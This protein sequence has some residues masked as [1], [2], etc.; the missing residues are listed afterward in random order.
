MNM[1]ILTIL[2]VDDEANMRRIMEATLKREGYTTITAANGK[3]ALDYLDKKPIHI[4]LTDLRMPVIDGM[5]L[6][7]ECNSRYPDIP[8]I[9]LT[10]HGTVETAVEAMKIGAFDYI[11]KPFDIIEMRHALTKASSQYLRNR[12]SYHDRGFSSGQP[13]VSR[14]KGLVKTDTIIAASRKMRD[15]LDLV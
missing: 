6:L 10:A 11:S 3:I 8:L 1:K 15:V 4:I 2:I 12:K 5:T 14:N 13:I 7:R 9:M